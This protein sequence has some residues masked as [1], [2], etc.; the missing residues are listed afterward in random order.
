MLLKGNNREI[1]FSKEGREGDVN[2]GE[3]WEEMVP[4]K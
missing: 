2:V 3:K 1:R 4:P